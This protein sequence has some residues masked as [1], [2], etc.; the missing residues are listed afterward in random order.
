MELL[1][2]IVTYATEA[3]WLAARKI[4]V[5]STEAAALFGESPY[6]TAFELHHRKAGTL[7][8]EDFTTNDRMKWG[9]RLEAAIAH[10][11][12]EDL[13]L[14]VEPFKVYARIPELRMG[15]SFDFKIV[16]I[17]DAFSGDEAARDMFRQHGAGIME[18]KN[19]D[20]LQFKR[21]W[22]DDGDAV[23]AP[24]HIELQVQHQLEVA[25]LEWSIIAPLVGGNTPRPIIR[26]RDHDVGSAIR[27]KVREFWVRI[28]NGIEP[29]P[30]FGRDKDTISALYVNNNGAEIDLTS[31]TRLAELCMNRKMAADQIKVAEAIKDAA[32]A[33]ILT[34]I[35]DYKKAFAAGGF[36]ISAGTTA[37]GLVSYERKPFRSIRITQKG[38]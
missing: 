29:T 38:A 3:Q 34:I 26:L 30:E 6:C 19:V 33:E 11:V 2:D 5:T 20:G 13:G 25:G 32:T 16:G 15:S 31:D 10:G 1:R 14:I 36:T 8:V 18:I 37:G 27:E 24:T 35:G 17:S 21:G 12:A 22:L 23:E 28:D 7:P 9:N 4:D